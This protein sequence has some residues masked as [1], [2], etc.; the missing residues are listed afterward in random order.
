MSITGKW[1]HKL[2]YSHTMEYYSGMKKNLLLLYAATWVN[3]K[4]I[5]L[6]EET[7]REKSSILNN[8]IYI[9][10]TNKHVI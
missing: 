7:R 4:I 8:S 5:L 6:S 3:L 9:E 10:D 1:I 2:C